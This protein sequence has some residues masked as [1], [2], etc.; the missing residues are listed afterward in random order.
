[1]KLTV[2]GA[3]PCHVLCWW[4][5]MYYG[6]IIETESVGC[7]YP[8]LTFLDAEHVHTVYFKFSIFTDT[9]ACCSCYKWTEKRDYVA[10]ESVIGHSEVCRQP[11][12][13]KRD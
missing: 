10:Q 13:K 2:I 6:M 12:T 9:H 11:K 7:L 5:N 3:S 1:M 4:C 8:M